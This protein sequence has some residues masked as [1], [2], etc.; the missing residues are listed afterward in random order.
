MPFDWD[1]ILNSLPLF[2]K[3]LGVTLALGLSAVA[4]SL[5]FGLAG[6]LLL[7]ARVRLLSP[8][9]R[10]YVELGRNTPLL[11]QL[12]FLYFGL[13]SLGIRLSGSTCALL[14]LSFLGTAY[15]IETLRAGLET[16]GRSELEAARSLG[17]S[18][19]QI[20]RH[21]QIP[22]ALSVSIPGLSANVLFLLKETSLVGIIAVPDLMHLTQDLLGLY[23]RTN[24]TLLLLTLSYLLI[25]VP[26]TIASHWIERSHGNAP[27]RA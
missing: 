13:P 12:F 16:I 15:M 24:E 5:L 26:L 27:L 11:A 17:L 9:L 18:G 21:I 4:I 23:Y 14:G 1:F 25:F 8:L 7:H 20:L 2:A 19:T 10:A 22:Q 6:A 3:A